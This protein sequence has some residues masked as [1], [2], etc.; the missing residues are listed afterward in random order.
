MTT[1]EFYPGNG[2]QKK[3]KRYYDNLTDFDFRG[4]VSR[5]LQE[6][7]D[8][9]AMQRNMESISSSQQ[10][11]E[12]W[13]DN[14]NRREYYNASMRDYLVPKDTEQR[15]RQQFVLSRNAV[16][17]AVDS[18]YNDTL[19]PQ[20][21]ANK[22]EADKR[23]NEV[24][25]N[26]AGVP[27]ANP[28]TALGYM[29]RE[30]DPAKVINKTMDSL[31]NDELDEITAPYARYAGFDPEAYREAV[32]KPNLQNRMVDEYVKERTPDSSLE[33]ISRAA[34]DNSL[35]GKI[36]NLGESAYAQSNSKRIIDD[37][38]MQNYNPNRVENFA[39]G[40]GSLLVDTAVFHTLGGV[41]GKATSGVTS[42]VKNRLASNILAKGAAR[43][44]TKESANAMAERLIV[45][46][47]KTKIMQ[48]SATQGLT[49]GAY[50]AANS[51]AD[52]LLHGNGVSLSS[53]AGAFA[54]GMGTGAALGVVGTPLREQARMLSGAKKML[55]NTGVLTAE[56][57][58]F[59]ASTE[60]G[61]I[62]SGIDVE[63]IDL[64][65]DFGESAATLLAMRMFHW[66]PD[67]RNK[68]NSMGRLK[69][70]L[71]FS[72]AER[73]E[74]E[75]AGVSVDSFVAD[76]EKSMRVSSRGFSKEA[77]EVKSQYMKL[78]ENPNLSA[79]ARSKLLF[80]V[81]NKI[82]STPPVPVDYSVERLNDGKMRATLYDITGGKIESKLFDRKINLETY[83]LTNTGTLRGNRLKSYEEILQRNYNTQDFFRQANEYAKEKNVDINLISDAMYKKAN[84]E[85]LSKEE[86]KVLDDILSRTAYASGELARMLSDMR[87][88][89]EAEYELHPGTIS[90][91]MNKNPF[92]CS[93]QLNAA[94]DKYEQLMFEQVNALKG[95]QQRHA[96]YKGATL[97][98]TN[99]EKQN[100]EREQ[101]EE[102][103]LNS[104]TGTLGKHVI[105]DITERLGEAMDYDKVRVPKKWDKPYV[106]SLFVT[107]KTPE[108]LQRYSKEAQKFANS[109]GVKLDFV[110]DERDIKNNN[111]KEYAK[112]IR[113]FGWY[114]T[115]DHSLVI[116]LPNHH[117]LDEVKRTVVH[118][119]VGHYG[120]AKVFGS[121]YHDFLEEL[122]YRSSSE[123]Q[124]E[125]K[126]LSRNN[127]IAMHDC[128][129]EYLA[130]LTE[131]TYPTGEQRTLL[132]YLRDFIKNML[133]RLKLYKSEREIG[134][135][136]IVRLL[137][138]HREAMARKYSS[139]YSRFD[140]FGDFQSSHKMGSYNDMRGYFLREKAKY[141]QDNNMNYAP[142]EFRDSRRAYMDLYF[143]GSEKNVADEATTEPLSKKYRFIG[144]EGAMN[145]KDANDGRYMSDLRK[146]VNM[147]E[148]G[149][150]P[151]MIK[152][153]TGW[154]I[155]GDGKW[156][157]EI[158]ENFEVKD[159]IYNSLLY[160]NDKM[161]YVYK[162]LISKPGQLT[163]NEYKLLLDIETKE[164]PYDKNAKLTDIIKDRFF[165]NAYPEF[166][167]MPVKFKMMNDKDCYYDSREKVLYMD[168]RGFSSPAL[169][170][171]ITVAMQRMIQDYENFSRGFD[172]AALATKEERQNYSEARSLLETINELKNEQDAYGRLDYFKDA[173]RDKFNMD[174]EEFQRSYPSLDDYVKGTRS[175]DASPSVGNVELR[176]VVN[177][178]GLSDHKRRASL[179]DRTEDVPRKYQRPSIYLDG[180]MDIIYSKIREIESDERYP[181][182]KSDSERDKPSRMS[183]REFEMMI[184]EIER[185]VYRDFYNRQQERIKESYRRK[186]KKRGGNNS[187]G[188]DDGILMN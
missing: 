129:D 147:R 100:A 39:A 59:T 141:D 23:G 125:I 61:K 96:K 52:D 49:L 65:H 43:G 139:A 56:S 99:A 164:S 156:R 64:V 163:P 11:M 137:T 40:V 187:D 84:G 24:Y 174:Y 80:I 94:L 95:G 131:Y 150:S 44:V 55:A 110:F 20:F 97:N 158:P 15:R 68:L 136:D 105:P 123:V 145:L 21:K 81:E 181:R 120:L 32:V 9:A 104:E 115:E 101:Y 111:D 144:T 133:V 7:D 157:M 149:Y 85:S 160:S 8:Y 175:G 161:F 41:A 45:N 1:N 16:D 73:E 72:L 60:V 142:K 17:D 113:S 135:D 121:Y 79:S 26:Y 162:N 19:Q 176:N 188:N 66:R 34:V 146:A 152:L 117:S 112:Q 108:E 22:E 179:A 168:K 91:Q 54:K 143:N 127:K 93:Q 13:G 83:L 46:N 77:L 42:I 70:E 166:K 50:D 86:G 6:S 30:T 14:E 76:L 36:E 37:I 78:M 5:S 177:R 172:Y 57:A 114:N 87:S 178:Y 10:R 90:H 106:W 186:G 122:Y 51:V 28:Y 180:P 92:R 29:R 69:G 119:V 71:R 3:K 183:E 98:M 27:G 25:K 134:K 170:R 4:S 151:N 74:I 102:D 130:K 128:V 38:A 148:E 12:E 47:I 184:D 173:F 82:T 140:V 31:D 89:I 167:Q 58:V 88:D 171:D 18:Y 103:L 169:G 124:H 155:G 154:E 138:N 53:A 75:K 67:M 35:L 116:N 159:Y 2:Q 182:I 118:E 109:F 165:F 48:S 33:Y 153:K 62:A 107:R 63:P 126:S 132:Q 185:K